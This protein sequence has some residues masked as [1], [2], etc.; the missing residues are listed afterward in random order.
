[1]YM[2]FKQAR[3]LRL[4]AFEIGYLVGLLQSTHGDVT[5]AARQSALP[6]GTLYRLLKK[7]SIVPEEFRRAS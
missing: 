2:A 1:M 5:E 6:R 4:A 3:D 7:H